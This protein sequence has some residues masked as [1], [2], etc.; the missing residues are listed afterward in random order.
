MALFFFDHSKSFPVL[1]KAMGSPVAFGVATIFGFS[2]PGCFAKR[3]GMRIVLSGLHQSFRY[4]IFSNVISP[5][6]K[7]CTVPD[8]MIRKAFLPDCKFRCQAM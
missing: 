1:L 6:V 5:S 3:R 4:G 2:R 7:V 8:A